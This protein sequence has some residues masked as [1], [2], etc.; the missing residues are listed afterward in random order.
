MDIL[1]NYHR[2]LFPYAYNILGSAAEARDAIQDV[3]VKHIS[4][5]GKEM[6]NEMGYLTMVIPL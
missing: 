3:I 6:D 2:K 5:P 4:T 1:D